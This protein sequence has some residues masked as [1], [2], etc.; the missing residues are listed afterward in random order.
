MATSIAHLERYVAR[1]ESI[2]DDRDMRGL[3]KHLKSLVGLDG[4]QTG[5]Q[6]PVKDE[7]GVMLRSKGGVL[8]R[9]ARF[10][11]T[12]LNAESPTL[13]PSIIEEVKQRPKVPT[14]DGSQHVGSAPTLEETQRA[15]RGMKNWKAPGHDSLPLEILNIDDVDDPIVIEDFHAILVK[16]W[17]RRGVP[18]EWKNATI[19]ELERTRSIPLNMYLVDLQKAYD[20]VDRELPARAGIPEEMIAVIRQFYDGMQ[21]RVRMDDGELSEWFE[22]TQGLGRGCVLFP[23]LFI[24]CF[25]APLEVVLVRFSEDEVTLGDLVYLE[26][27]AGTRAM[28]PLERVRKAVWGMLYAD[29][30]EFVSRSA[31]GLAR[32]MT[33]IGEIGSFGLTVSEKKTEILLMK[34]P[35]KKPRKGAPPPPPP[36]PTAPQVIEAAGQKYAQTAEFRYLGSRVRED[37]ELTKEINHGAEQRG[38]VS[39]TW[40]CLRKYARECFDRP[41]AL[42]GL[43][44]RLLKAEAMEALLIGCMT[45]A[46]RRKHYDLLTTTRHRLLLRVI[47]YRR[48]RGQYRQLSNAQALKYVECQSVEATVR[49][50]RLLFA[51]AVARQSDGRL[52]KRL[53]LGD[54]VGGKDPES[55]RSEK[56]WVL[57]LKDD[58][59]EFGANAESTAGDLR[60][61]GIPSGC[62]PVIAKLEK[63]V[64]WF[65]GVMEGA[66]KFM[67]KWHK[68]QEQI[69][70]LRAEERN[71]NTGKKKEGQQSRG[72][73]EHGRVKRRKTEDTTEAEESRTEMTE[74]IE[75]CVPG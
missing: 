31:E 43:K 35:E 20:S 25:A 74:Q 40:A 41:T 48:A 21:A 45:W 34:V 17:N 2:L 18:Q 49:Q 26:E 27:E 32:M 65:K 7:N 72:G 33:S 3:Y 66:E 1:M 15:A 28:T 47:G 54:I 71:K 51:G 38:L 75:R 22:V 63:E 58:F 64:P 37:V 67:V 62:W 46:P 23:L 56:N 42:W 61:F 14:N 53:M 9:W 29:D 50:R 24:I 57:C 44:I 13:N 69:I 6:Q 4:R 55:G 19:K 8:R 39:G 30:A 68:E 36:P 12:L 52:P 59:V 16:V 11:G 10:F 70:I 60:T 73:R 5:G